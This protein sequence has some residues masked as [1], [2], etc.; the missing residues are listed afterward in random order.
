MNQWARGYY[1]QWESM[2]QVGRLQFKSQLERWVAD[3]NEDSHTAALAL[4]L[5]NGGGLHN[6]ERTLHCGAQPQALTRTSQ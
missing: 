5:I 1:A 2:D 3:E 6:R 4:A